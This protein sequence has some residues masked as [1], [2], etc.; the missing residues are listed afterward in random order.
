MMTRQNSDGFGCAHAPQTPDSYATVYIYDVN[1]GEKERRQKN[2]QFFAEKVEERA[3]RALA[4]IV[5]SK[6]VVNSAH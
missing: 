2:G 4:I 1:N 6:K 3:R 5:I